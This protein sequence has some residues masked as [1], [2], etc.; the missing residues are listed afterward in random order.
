V[1]LTGWFG[2]VQ[3]GSVGYHREQSVDNGERMKGIK[4]DSL[5]FKKGFKLDMNCV[6]QG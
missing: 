3:T 4:S 5:G 1:G 6:K 2:D